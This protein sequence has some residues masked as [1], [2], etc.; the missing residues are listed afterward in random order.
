MLFIQKYDETILPKEFHNINNICAI[1]FDQIVDIYRYGIYEDF[2]SHN[3]FFGGNIKSIDI[4]GFKSEDDLIRFLLDN[5]LRSELNDALTKKICSAIISDFSHFV[6]EAISSAKKCKTTVAFSLLRKPFTDELTILERL[7]VD[8]EG[9]IENFYIEGDINK[10]DPSNDR[11]KNNIDHLELIRDCKKKMKYSLLIFPSLVYDIRYEK[12]FK[13]AIQEVTNKSIH[14][15]TKQRYYK[16]EAKDLNYIFDSVSNIDHYLHLFYTNTF[17]MLLYSA[18]IIDELYFKY[19]T[20][21]EHVTLRKSKALRR[22]FSMVLLRGF[23]KDESDIQAFEMIL[24]V[25]EKNKMQCSTCSHEFTPIGTDLEYF[26][27]E[28][29]LKCPRCLNTIIN[30]EKDLEAFVSKFEIILNVKNND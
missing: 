25:F 10:Y 2:T 23:C 15:V 12:S 3:I 27:F 13:G 6:Y 5:N 9:F 20:N 11:T 4:E 1:L 16:T 21:Q 8:P 18:S 14:I 19:L 29:N 26:F 28:E 17:Y 30:S 7:F 24:S 22:L